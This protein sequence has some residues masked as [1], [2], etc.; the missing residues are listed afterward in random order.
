MRH[1]PRPVRA[2]ATWVGAVV[3]LCALYVAATGVQV[4]WASRSDGAEAADA[5]VVLGAAQYDGVPSPALEGRLV[6]ALELYRAGYADLVV[7]TGANQPGDRFTQGFAGYRW[8][9]DQG[10]PDADILVVVDGTN[11]WEE[12]TATARVLLD[13]DLH[14]VVLVSDPYHALRT[15]EIAEAVGLD[16]VSSPTDAGASASR[17]L[18]E[19]AGVA[20]GRLIGYSRLADLT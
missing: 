8:L 19:S 14:R 16:A 18:Q 6:H 11:T 7:T 1:L 13:R 15:V 5:I 12:L 10:V 9:R 3:V 17:L 2:A 20:L 4:W